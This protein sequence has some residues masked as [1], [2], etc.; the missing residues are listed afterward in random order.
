M[1]KCY[2]S[3]S[4]L[5]VYQMLNN[6]ILG[7]WADFALSFVL[8]DLEGLFNLIRSFSYL[9]LFKPTIFTSSIELLDE[10]RSTAAGGSLF[11]AVQLRP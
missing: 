7:G 11:S 3:S 5:D 8:R 4:E 9:H 2:F 10:S 1:C 6:Q